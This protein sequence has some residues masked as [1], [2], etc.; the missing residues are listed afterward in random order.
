MKHCGQLKRT[1]RCVT[2]MN[3]MP[4]NVLIDGDNIHMDAF[5]THVQDRIDSRFGMNYAPVLFCQSNVLI[6]YKQHRSA[7]L[8]VCCS[9][10]TNKNASDARI[11]LETGKLIATNDTNVVVIVSNDRIFEEIA[12]GQRIH[13]MGYTN[14]TKSRKLKPNNVVEVLRMLH[15]SKLPSDDIYIDDLMEYFSGHNKSEVKAFIAANVSS[16][17]V[18]NNDSVYF[19]MT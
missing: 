16:V 8:Q 13:V 7:S 18:S 10:T 9:N 19:K 12:D 6:K 2:K 4:L 3:T 15:I 5:L 11:I 17:R 14:A 1:L